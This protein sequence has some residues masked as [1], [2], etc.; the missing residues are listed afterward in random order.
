MVADHQVRRV[1]VVKHHLVVLVH[2]GRALE[3]RRSRPDV[4]V[5]THVADGA[6]L[7]L[8][9]RRDV[10]D[11]G[12]ATPGGVRGRHVEIP[13]HVDVVRTDAALRVV[14][15]VHQRQDLRPTR[16]QRGSVHH[17]DS[18]DGKVAR[19]VAREM[20]AEGLP[21]KIGGIAVIVHPRVLEGE[22]GGAPEEG[23]PLLLVGPHLLRHHVS[24]PLP[25]IRLLQ[26]F[27]HPLHALFVEDLLHC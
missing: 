4:I 9:Q 19:T 11:G 16:L 15:H 27:R 18:A 13:A 20:P 24:P 25:R 23:V 1:P 17:V 10:A 2:V 26:S 8:E 22:R 6:G 7:G 3:A 14:H 12:E 5:Q 21:L